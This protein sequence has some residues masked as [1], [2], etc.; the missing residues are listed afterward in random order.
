[1]SFAPLHIFS[2]SIMKS[3]LRIKCSGLLQVYNFSYGCI[4]YYLF[5]LLFCQPLWALATVKLTSAEQGW[6]AQNP[7]VYVGGSPDWTPFDFAD[8][9]GGHRGL[10]HD[11]LQLVAEKTG[12]TLEISI[13]PWFESLEKIQSNKIDLLG[14]V[15]YTED[16]QRYLN[17][18]KPYFE[19]LDFFFIRDDIEAQTYDDLRGKRV[20]LPKSYAHIDFLA[21]H[22][23]EIEVVLVDT[24]GDAIDAVLE[25]RAEL[26]YD[27]YGSLIYT[28]EKKGVNTIIPFKSTS[29]LGDKYIHIATRKEL[30]ELATIVQK[31]L[32]AIT[33][34]EKREVSRR[35]L[36]SRAS[37]RVLEK[38]FEISSAEREWLLTNPVVRFSGDP[39]WLPYEAFN[40]QG[41]YIGIVADYLALI[42]NKLGI[43][44]EIIPTASWRESVEK[45]KRGEIDVLSETSDSDLKSHLK[46]TRD[47]VSSPLVIVMNQRASYVE[48]ID[49]LKNKK[50]ALIWDYGYVPK[51]VNTYPDIDFERVDSIQEGLSAV[52]TSKV[53][54]LVATLAQASYHISDLGM[55]NIR[56]VGQTEFET[57]LAFGVRE[58]F[59][60]LLDLFDRALLS[61]TPDEKQKIMNKWGE[62]KYT[63]KHDYSLLVQV[64]VVLLLIILFTLYWNR[65]LAREVA[66]RKVAEEQTR[67]LID[68]IPLQIVVTSYEGHILSANPQALSDHQVGDKE[69]GRYNILDF[70]VN[71]SDR[72]SV[73]NEMIKRGAVDQKIVPMYGR[74]RDIRQMMLSI[75][76]IVYLNTPALLS[77][78]VDLTDRLEF[79]DALS[80]AKEYAEAASRAKSEFLANMSHEI[81]TPMNAVLGFTGLLMEQ[82]DDPK[83]KSF[84]KTIQT[85]G[86]NLLVLIN[87]ILDLSKIEAGKL[88][89]EKT[90]CNPA[91]QLWELSDIFSLKADDKNIELVFELD[92]SLPKCL[93]LDAVR[94]RQVLFNLLGNAIKFTERGVIRVHLWADNE[95]EV[96]SQVDLSISVEDSGIGISRE[97]QELVF[98]QFT[99]SSGQ[100]GRKYGGTGLGLSITK[101]LVEMMGG[102]LILSS[103]LGKGSVFTVKLPGVD[104]ASM[105]VDPVLGLDN[106]G[107]GEVTDFL[108]AKILIVDDVVDN[109]A[110]LKA[111]FA[112]TALVLY[113]ATN[114]LEALN[115]VTEQ[116]F[117]LILMD[118]HMPVMAGYEAAARIKKIADVPIVALTASVMADEFAPINKVN[119]D[120][121]LR[122]PVSKSEL[123]LEL[124]RF[125]PFETPLLT[126]DLENE[127]TE[128]LAD[129]TAV[130][131]FV[132]EHLEDLS[133]HYDTISVG[134]NLTEI[135]SFADA[136]IEI[137]ERYPFEHLNNYAQQLLEQIAVFDIPAIKRSINT[138]PQLI[139]TIEKMAANNL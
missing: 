18:S 76:P 4:A 33:E 117:D 126:E 96:R 48:G 19:V 118:I 29:H 8:D 111:N 36:G 78:A 64:A 37:G 83:L 30:P 63:E 60:P 95:D 14:A 21:E 129:E 90:P 74:D 80:R 92:S 101:R 115:L 31:G 46:F 49:N 35:W 91:D 84:V 56:I 38:P 81:R 106:N 17:F 113:S 79:E 69:M 39:N 131:P 72:K 105:L 99:Q 16:R 2:T 100:D 45:L 53:D 134:N 116:S 59:L 11:Y 65:K 6:I 122:K 94:L 128:V 114:G 119:F 66:L 26:L 43:S 7:V 103:E 32:D 133:D 34:E 135:A 89:I 51:I 58:E 70:Y 40:E 5:L 123:F 121:Y 125:L 104:I 44:L 112:D 25:H 71:K 20:A 27:T 88:T 1:M 28:I 3:K 50:I 107:V 24:F 130:I 68:K 61:I 13:A 75:T 97:Q 108:P 138:Y 47:Y 124:S 15:H 127:Y 54:A 132:V 98:Q 85:A 22:F 57:Q 110:L 9:N 137:S 67:I 41:E 93:H 10:V 82:V 62:H 55:N 87:D 139:C 136:L 12:I 23:P 73:L 102:T 52:S 42:E 77:L 86:N 109:R 120:G